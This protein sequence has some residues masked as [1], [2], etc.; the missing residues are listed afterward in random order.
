MI[1]LIAIDLDGTLLRD[2]KTISDRTKSAVKAAQDAGV[3]VVICSGRP[4]NAI[5]DILNELGLNNPENHS[6]TYNGGMVVQNKSQ[7]IISS[8]HLTFEETIELYE[9]FLSLGMPVGCIDAEVG[10]YFDDFSYETSRYVRD[11][12]KLDHIRRDADDL[13]ADSVFYK[14]VMAMDTGE[15]LQEHMDN[16]DTD[17]YEKYSIMR[18]HPHQ[19]ELMPKGIDKGAGL[20]SL[21]EH[22]GLSMESVM[23]IGDEENDIGMLESVGFPVVMANGSEKLKKMAK[24]V[25][26]SNEEDGVAVVIEALL[27]GEL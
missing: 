25:T 2:D 15:V 24:K 4:Y 14:L 20:R 10:Y 7:K 21:C 27:A 18:S 16:M 9:Y 23:G 17:L 6:I 11:Q 5:V 22:L 8:S 3:E 19:L 13:P 12:N 26:L 1:D